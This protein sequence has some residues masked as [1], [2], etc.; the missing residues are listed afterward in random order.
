MKSKLTKL[1]LLFFFLT[2]PTFLIAQTDSTR[3]AVFEVTIE[4]GAFFPLSR[5]FHNDYNAASTFNWSLGTRFGLAGYKNKKPLRTL[6]W[7]KYSRF[8][9][10]TGTEIRF[11]G[12]RTENLTARR[13]QASTGIIGLLAMKNNHF[14]QLKAGISYSNFFES[15]NEYE[16]GTVGFIMA[17]GYMKK[18]SKYFT[19]YVDLNFDYAKSNN[20]SIKDWSGV[21]LNFG[22][23]FNL[24]AK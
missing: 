8:Q 12:V 1:I 4:A 21:L 23:S 22:L 3:S 2:S 17:F 15:S 7:I 5:S 24:F 9:I 10:S 13:E 18:F 6:A 20:K 14:L 16:S 19:Y 11:S